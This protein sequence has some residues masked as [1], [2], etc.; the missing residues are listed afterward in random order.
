[1]ITDKNTG[2]VTKQLSSYLP[3]PHNAGVMVSLTVVVNETHPEM[4]DEEMLKLAEALAA[5]LEVEE[6]G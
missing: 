3:A 6:E 4:S 1:V 5:T 2:E